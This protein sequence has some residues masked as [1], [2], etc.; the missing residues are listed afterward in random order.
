MRNSGINTYGGLERKKDDIQ[1]QFEVDVWMEGTEKEKEYLF[2][3]LLS[4][5]SVLFHNTS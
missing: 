5:C 1:G 2:F 3:F 4:S